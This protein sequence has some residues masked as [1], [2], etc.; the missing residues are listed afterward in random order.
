M[1]YFYD[2]TLPVVKRLGQGCAH[3]IG[4][5]SDDSCV[6]G[7]SGD[8]AGEAAVVRR[9]IVG[10]LAEKISVALLSIT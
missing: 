8:V 1:L 7:V 4:R 3:Q 2:E 10:G 5:A 6:G 9:L